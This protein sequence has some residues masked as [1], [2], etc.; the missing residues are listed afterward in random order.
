MT[1]TQKMTYG[2]YR[3][4][5]TWSLGTLRLLAK[6]AE[7]AGWQKMK[8]SELINALWESYIDEE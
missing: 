5:N 7:I 3:D 2:Y 8:K 1:E 6:R 4:L